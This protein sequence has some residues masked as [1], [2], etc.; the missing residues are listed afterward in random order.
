MEPIGFIFIKS[1]KCGSTTGSSITVRMAQSIAR[2]RGH[3]SEMC[4][5]W[6]DHK[7]AYNLQVKQRNKYDSLLWSV[8]RNP[9]SRV[10]SEFFHFHV[11]RE[12]IS[13]SDE[14]FMT[15]LKEDR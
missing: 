8:I 11:S 2:K 13:S 4:Q 1:K 10:V 7:P 14:A 12:N 6:T 15:F 3:K 5:C 9:I